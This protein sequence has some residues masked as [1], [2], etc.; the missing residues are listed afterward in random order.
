MDC[1]RYSL[2]WC[3]ECFYLHVVPSQTCGNY[4]SHP[5]PMA[6]HSLVGQGVF[7][8]KATRSHPDTPHTE[9][10]LWRGDQPVAET[11]TLQHTTLISDRHASGGI[12]TH[13]PSKQAAVDPRASAG[14]GWN[15]YRRS[16]NSFHTSTTD[17]VYS[18]HRV[19]CVPTHIPH[20]TPPLRKTLCT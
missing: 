6:W 20:L 11:T 12:R 1:D 15:L 9:G 17:T 18:L 2:F 4:A 19:T 13:S 5:P 8:V 7:T 10:L 3:G 14:T 16:N